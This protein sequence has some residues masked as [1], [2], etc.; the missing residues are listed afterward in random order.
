MNDGWSNE[1]KG[2]FRRTFCESL[3]VPEKVDDQGGPLT[4]DVFFYR[5]ALFVV[6]MF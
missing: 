4:K 6:F 1:S 3:F 5:H 2:Y